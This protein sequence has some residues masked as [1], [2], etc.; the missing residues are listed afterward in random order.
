MS[1]CFAIR[2]PGDAPSLVGMTFPDQR[3][4]ISAGGVFESEDSVE[5]RLLQQVQ[6]RGKVGLGL[7]RG[8]PQSRS[9]VMLSS[10]RRFIT[11]RAPVLFAV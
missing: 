5:S 2:T 8:S 1:L 6:G 4:R 7:A 3:G 9:V 10:L 11:P